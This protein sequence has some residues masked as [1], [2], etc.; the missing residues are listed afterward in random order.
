MKH[1]SYWVLNHHVIGI[2]L[3]EQLTRKDYLIEGHGTSGER[4]IFSSTVKSTH[5]A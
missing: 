1:N 4:N 2:Y 5:K 3:V